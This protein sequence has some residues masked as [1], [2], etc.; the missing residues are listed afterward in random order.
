MLEFIHQIETSYYIGGIKH[1]FLNI[2]IEQSQEQD[3]DSLMAIKFDEK[4][5]VVP[6]AKIP[7]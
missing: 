5:S 7:Q 1:T 4:L 2:Y 6:P 3:P